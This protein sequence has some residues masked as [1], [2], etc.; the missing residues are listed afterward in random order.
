METC[1][2]REIFCSGCNGY[3][4]V[5]DIFHNHDICYGKKNR[6]CE[7]CDESLRDYKWNE[8]DFVKHSWDHRKKIQQME[9][10]VR[11]KNMITVKCCFC[12]KVFQAQGNGLSQEEKEK[13]TEKLQTDVK[14]HELQC[15]TYTRKC[16]SCQR[17]FMDREK[18]DFKNCK[19]I[20]E[21]NK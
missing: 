1:G 21:H 17:T 15:G 16:L 13:T 14:Q 5:I 4:S 8:A 6:K 19:N 18:H 7:F 2:K 12:P 11:R 9:E 10:E 20:D 3:L